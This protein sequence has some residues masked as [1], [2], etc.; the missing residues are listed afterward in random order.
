MNKHIIPICSLCELEFHEVGAAVR[1]TMRKYGMNG[2]ISFSHGYCLRHFTKL[3]Q[4]YGYTHEEIMARVDKA[5]TDINLVP[6]LEQRLDL[7]QWW[8][9]GI[10]IEEQ[11]QEY[12]QSIQKTNTFLTE[13]FKTLAGIHS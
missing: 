5:K 11:R 12:L 13:R 7:V 3:M 4:E 6:D 9:M 2:E 1:H 8:S 10:F